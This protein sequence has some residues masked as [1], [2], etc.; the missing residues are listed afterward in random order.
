ME[1]STLSSFTEMNKC[2]I[3]FILKI[4]K[5]KNKKETRLDTPKQPNLAPSYEKFA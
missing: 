3:R 2:E 5:N 1:D 4:I